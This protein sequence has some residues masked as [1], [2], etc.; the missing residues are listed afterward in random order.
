MGMN[1]NTGE[2]GTLPEMGAEEEE[3]FFQQQKIE[4]QLAWTKML[5]EVYNSFLILSFDGW[6][7]YKKE[8]EIC[9]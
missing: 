4:R 8:M 1:N 9:E 3:G 7:G 2:Y 5:S 6:K